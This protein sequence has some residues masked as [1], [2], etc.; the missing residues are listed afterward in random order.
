MWR[1]AYLFTVTPR[2]LKEKEKIRDSSDFIIN[3]TML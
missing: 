2:A 3:C 1:E